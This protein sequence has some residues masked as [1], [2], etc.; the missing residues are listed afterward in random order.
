MVVSTFNP[1]KNISHSQ[2]GFIFPKFRDGN[3]QIV[4]TTIQFTIN[5]SRVDYHFNGPLD[6]EGM[7]WALALNL[8][9][10]PEKKKEN[11]PGKA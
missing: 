4:E 9:Q 5:N 6:F 1:L 2:N 11:M 3:T 8:E 10:V 7:G